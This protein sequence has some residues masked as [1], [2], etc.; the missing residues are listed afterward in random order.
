MLL[1]RIYNMSNSSDIAS[2]NVRGTVQSLTTELG[3]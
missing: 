1:T 3:A 2:L